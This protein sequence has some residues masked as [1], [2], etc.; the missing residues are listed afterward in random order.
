MGELIRCLRATEEQC[1]FW[2]TH[3]G[4]ELDLLIVRGRE[5]LGFKDMQLSRLYV[6]HAGRESF[7]LGPGTRALAARDLLRELGGYSSPRAMR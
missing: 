5:R 6:V 1:H 3:A 2:A 7:D 4:A